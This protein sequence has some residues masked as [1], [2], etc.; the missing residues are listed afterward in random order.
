MPRVDI[1]TAYRGPT[2]GE[3]VIEVDGETVGAC[4]REA[5]DR[6]PGLGELVFDADGAVLRFVKLFV[7][8]EQIDRTAL[9]MSV[10]GDD[11]VQILA[12][13]AGG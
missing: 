10:S 12:A 8:G 7:N 5:V 4:L 9:D 2:H 6:N 1:P 3:A 13:I 11:Q